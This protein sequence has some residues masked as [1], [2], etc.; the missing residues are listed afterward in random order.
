MSSGDFFNFDPVTPANGADEGAT[1]W[2]FGDDVIGSKS[3]EAGG[4]KSSYN[5]P[6]LNGQLFGTDNAAEG[7]NGGKDAPLTLSQLMEDESGGDFPFDLS[8]NAPT[9]LFADPSMP[10]PESSSMGK[11]KGQPK[12]PPVSQ[13]TREKINA[14]GKRR[15]VASLQVSGSKTAKYSG[16]GWNETRDGDTGDDGAGGGRPGKPA[17]SKVVAKDPQTP[18]SKRVQWSESHSEPSSSGWTKPALDRSDASE[19]NEDIV[20]IS[21]EETTQENSEVHD[22]SSESPT[23]TT[24]TGIG[25][26]SASFDE[27]PAAPGSLRE[28]LAGVSSPPPRQ[29]Q[30]QQRRPPTGIL[31]PPPKPSMVS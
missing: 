1:S 9:S 27:F 20:D 8:Y 13:E 3:G 25:S 7:G 18:K 19:V 12:S 22:A 24:Q 11:K 15:A 29:Q 14:N 5:L 17:T 21:G 10:N 6:V 28:M 31:R 2:L 26:S 4:V 23:D 16:S 30:Q